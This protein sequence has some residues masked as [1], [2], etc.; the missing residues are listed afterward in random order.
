MKQFSST[1]KGIFFIITSAFCFALMAVFVRLAG[2]IHF[3]QKAFFRNAVAFIISLILLI[4]DFRINGAQSIHVPTAAWL[5]LFLRAATG[6][7]GV[8]GNFYAIDRIVLSDAAILNKMAPF[9][10]ILFSFILMKERIKPIPL[11]A[12]SIAFLGAMLV[13]K[14]SFD[15]SKTIPTVVAF[16]GGAG[17]GFAYACVRKLSYLKCNGKIIVLFF[18]IFSMTLSI[19]FMITNF[20]PMT[21]KQ[22]LFLCGAGVSAAGGQFT[23]T[24][25]YYHAPAKDISI[26]DY[27]QII[28][29]TLMGFFFFGQ[30]PDVLSFVG[31]VIIVLM[32]LLNFIYQTGRFSNFKSKSDL[33]EN[34]TSSK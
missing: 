13:V 5:Y 23:I 22:F 7:I 12:I 17:A 34:N 3:V 9:F 24:A 15:F 16:I 1:T 14:P 27:S 21:L 26:Y 2:D 28:F 30:L 29:S 32:A 33:K 10:A 19:P 31:Y 25:A 18:S 20:N 6:S 11:I 4:R 8:F